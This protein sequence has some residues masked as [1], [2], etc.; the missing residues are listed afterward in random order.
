MDYTKMTTTRALITQRDIA[1]EALVW[2][3]EQR[4]GWR[5]KVEDAIREMPESLTACF[6]NRK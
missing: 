2:A 3:S 4:E 6:H 1:V 5:E